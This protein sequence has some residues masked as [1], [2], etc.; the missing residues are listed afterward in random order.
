MGCPPEWLTPAARAS[1]AGAI[2][3]CIAILSAV[4]YGSYKF[5]RTWTTPIIALAILGFFI[6]LEWIEYVKHR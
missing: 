6:I 2:I 1:I 4:I 5:L 3:G